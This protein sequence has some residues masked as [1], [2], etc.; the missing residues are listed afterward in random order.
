MALERG[1][2]FCVSHWNLS[3]KLSYHIEGEMVDGQPLLRVAGPREMA[4]PHSLIVNKAGRRFADKSSFGDVA[5]KLRE[6]DFRSHRLANVPCFLIFNSQYLEKY[7]LPPLPPGTQAPN[8]LPS[9]SSITELAQR[10]GLDADVLAQTVERFNGFVTDNMDR[11][12]HRGEMPW[13]RQAASDL[14]QRNPNLGLVSEPP[15]FGLAVHPSQGQ[16]VGLVTDGI[17]RVTHLR[18]API[19]GLYA[20]GAVASWRHAGVG[21]QAGLSLAGAMTFGWLAALHAA[22]KVPPH[23]PPV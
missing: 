4:Y 11:D 7:G 16:A 23:D 17:G 9:A 15:F 18:G 2:A 10:L 3:T 14:K 5:T 13:A 8:W 20:C 22:G 6:F 12:F 21:Y 19:P 1:S